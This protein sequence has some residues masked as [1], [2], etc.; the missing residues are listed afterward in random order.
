VS[1]IARL[2]VFVAVLAV[3]GG[4]TPTVAAP[5]VS[6]ATATLSDDLL[7]A[8]N[9]YRAAQNLAPFTAAAP[10]ALLAREHSEHMLE[11]GF[12]AH[13]APGGPTFATR[14]GGFLTGEGYRSWVADE[15][16]AAAFGPSAAAGAVLQQW[17]DSEPHNANLLDPTTPAIGIGAAHVDSGIGVWAGLGGVTVVTAIFGPPQPELGRSALATKVGAGTVLVRLP[18]QKQAH[19]LGKTE[20][21][22]VGAEVDTTTGRVRLTSAADAAGHV[23]TADFYQGRFLFTY[24]QEVTK[25][26]EPMALTDL[27]LNGPLSCTTARRALSAADA[28]PT[29]KPTKR[30]LWGSGK[31]GFRTTAK[32]AAATVRGTVWLTEDTCTTTLVS[33][34]NG[35]VE[36]Y[37]V[38]K[39]QRVLVP[40]GKSYVARA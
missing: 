25:T 33:V 22:P 14:V 12:F 16:I 18:G 4:G 13:D 11:A 35:L 38:K 27:R 28:K 34:R 7:A 32:F 21:I 6:R 37:D 9:A 29:P 30:R 20:L 8:I 36:V 2:A 15:N 5:E 39:R 23:Q 17:I 31:G 24:A 1:I 40:A 19:P 3:L 10:Y 26:G